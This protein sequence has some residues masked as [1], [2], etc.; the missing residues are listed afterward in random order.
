MLALAFF[1]E[2][3]P[4]LVVLMAYTMSTLFCVGIL[5]GNNNALA[6]EPL[7]KVA[8]IGAA[9]VGSLSTFVSIPLGTM[10]GQSYNGTVIPLIFGFGILA[11]F[12]LFVFN[13]VES[14]SE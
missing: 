1:F 10:V 12:S 11:L 13:W 4:P 7:G 9:I 2:G 6:M 14:G 5:F 8:G 3:Q